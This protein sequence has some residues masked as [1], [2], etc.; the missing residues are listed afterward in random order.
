MEGK[1]TYVSEL[2]GAGCG[3]LHFWG[4]VTL[5]EPRGEGH[6]AYI[7]CMGEFEEAAPR[8]GQ[9]CFAKYHIGEVDGIIPGQ[10]SPAGEVR[11]VD[12]I[13]CRG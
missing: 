12:K 8:L 2:P 10:M 4:K 1:V 13:S 7:S 9:Y 6:D 11:I 3:I 5:S